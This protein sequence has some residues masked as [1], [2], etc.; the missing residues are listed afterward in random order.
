MIFSKGLGLD[1]GLYIQGLRPNRREGEDSHRTFSWWKASS[2]ARVA[3]LRAARELMAL[4]RALN[5]LKHL[6]G[7]RGRKNNANRF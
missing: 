2:T 5:T 3:M 4:W 6:A 1:L 7:K